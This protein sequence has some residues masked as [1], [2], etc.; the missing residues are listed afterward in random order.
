MNGRRAFLSQLATTAA[1]GASGLTAADEACGEPREGRDPGVADASGNQPECIQPDYAAW[2]RI[3]EKMAEA[4]V[5]RILGEPIGRRG[6]PKKDPWTSDSVVRASTWVYGRIDFRSLLVP[7]PDEFYIAIGNGQVYA[8]HDPFGG[9][10]STDGKPT[11]PRLIYPASGAA[12]DHYP[13]YLDLRWYPSSGRYPMHYIVEKQWGN[14][15]PRER[16]GAV[17]PE[18]V[19]EPHSISSYRVDIP[20]LLILHGGANPGRWRV[21]AVNAIGESDWSEHRE[22]AFRA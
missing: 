21:K 1:I 6:P 17:V 10:L 11:V 16:N 12:Y 7:Q 13:R 3:Q 4:E 19:W 2:A 22:Y 8:K 14:I 20:Y 15:F 18:R 5:L 9:R